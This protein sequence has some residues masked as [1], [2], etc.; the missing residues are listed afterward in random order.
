MRAGQGPEEGWVASLQ[1]GLTQA[2]IQ[3]KPVL[4]DF[5]A[6]W[7]LPCL[8]LDRKTFSNPQVKKV[9]EDFVRIKI[10]CTLENTHCEEA[11]NR[12][13]VIGWPTV[14]FLDR[15]QNLQKDLS[16]IGGFVGPEKMEELLSEVKRRG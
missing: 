7:C 12:Y 10:D 5:Y 11:V 13:G 6:D 2:K 1:E 15:D 16:V 4:I 3:K 9:L 14:L 8:E